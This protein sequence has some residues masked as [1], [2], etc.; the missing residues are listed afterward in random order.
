[1][2]GGHKDE[3]NKLRTPRQR[4]IYRHLQ[5]GEQNK[6]IADRL[7]ISTNT[8]AYYIKNIFKQLGVSSRYLIPETPAPTSKTTDVTK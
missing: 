1:M 3:V 4:D 8:V 5:R 6:E 7:N 2:A